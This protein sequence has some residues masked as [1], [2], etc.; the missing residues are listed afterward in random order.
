MLFL[1]FF[2]YLQYGKVLKKS[3]TSCF[4]MFTINFIIII[5]LFCLFISKNSELIYL[6]K[7]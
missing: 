7:F 4:G 6:F 5:G 1:F 2:S 3:C